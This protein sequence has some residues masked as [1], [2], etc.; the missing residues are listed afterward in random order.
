MNYLT[1]PSQCPCCNY[2]LIVNGEYLQCT[3]TSSCPAQTSG[4]I[5][6]WI[7]ELN[8]LDWGSKLIDKLLDSG[9]VSDIS[10]LYL[11]TV[12]D[13]ASLD[14]M[15][16]KS[17]KKCYDL[18]WASSELPLEVFVGALSIP[19]IGQSTVKQVMSCGF[20]TLEKL[21]SATINQLENVPNVGPTRA[22]SLVKGLSNNKG[23][24]ERI[25]Q[26]GVK[27][28]TKT[29]GKLT[30]MSFAITGSLS[31]KRAEAEKMITDA[32]GEMKS[33]VGKN[34]TYLI[35]ADPGSG[36]SKIESAKKNGTK[37]LSEED[38][39]KMLGD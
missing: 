19:L 4:R 9:K 32:G 29:K 3:N 36:S 1:S 10:D 8:I 2:N 34:T 16:Q 21:M 14:R 33:S 7:S 22:E 28:K 23:M 38:F 26:N 13:L 25:L 5:Q 31:M 27:I 12:D 18:L 37:I 15:G 35:V 6:N 17:A 11:L 24:I 30:G 39:V 20:D